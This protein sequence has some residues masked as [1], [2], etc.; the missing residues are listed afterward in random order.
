MKLSITDI[1]DGN[2]IIYNLGTAFVVFSGTEAVFGC[3]KALFELS[4]SDAVRSE[5]IKN[6]FRLYWV[7]DLFAAS[8]YVD[9][10]VSTHIN[11]ISFKLEAMHD[12]FL[13]IKPLGGAV[14]ETINEESGSFSLHIG[15]KDRTVTVNADGSCSSERGE[16]KLRR[17][18]SKFYIDGVFHA[19]LC[20]DDLICFEREAHKVNELIFDGKELNESN[21]LFPYLLLSE[22][23]LYGHFDEHL[24]DRLFNMAEFLSKQEKGRALAALNRYLRAFGAPPRREMSAKEA[25]YLTNTELKYARRNT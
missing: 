3:E 19:R 23:L 14:L 2:S 12:C 9:M 4:F 25:E 13:D 22:G 1:E 18:I 20:K 15:T 5:A 11:G 16:F 17:G 24:S 7:D 21:P 10:T 8:S 6:G